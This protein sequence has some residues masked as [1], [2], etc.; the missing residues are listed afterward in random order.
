MNNKNITL[1]TDSYKIGHHNQYPK[2][3]R[4]VYSYFEARKGAKYSDTTFFG[5]QALLKKY[6]AGV[7]VTSEIVDKAETIIDA[8]LGPDTF[9][10]ERW[11][12]IVEK[13]KGKLPVRIKAVPEGM[14]IPI[15]NVMMTVENTDPDCFWLTNHLETILTHVWHAS[16]VATLS[17]HTKKDMMDYLSKTSDNPDAINFMLHDFGF[18]GVS[19]LESAESGGAGHLI[20]FLGT[21]TVPA[22]IFI[23]DYYNTTEVAGYS[24][25]A[26][27]HSV[28]TAVGK[29]REAEVIGHLLEEYPTGIISVVSDSYDIFNCAENIIGGMYKEKILERDGKFVVRPDSGEPVST[30]LNLLEILGN[31]FGFTENSK[32][33][34]VLNPK[35]GLIWGDGIDHDGINAILEAM[36]KNKWAADNAV[37]GCGG[38]LLQKINRDTQ[39]FAFKSSAQLRNGVWHDVYKE[40]KDMSKASKRGRLKLVE[41][42]GSHGKGFTTVREDE[43]GEDVLITVFENGELLN[44]STFEEIRK[45]AKIN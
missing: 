38:G 4:G 26:T 34:K 44:Q 13:H 30:M 19:S 29:E 7:V 41:I 37:F 31:K 32:G 35:I 9:H 39:R 10:R 16:T 2:N 6:L 45:R 21:D 33:F 11:D 24:V 23:M 25:V 28:M 22:L 15:N 36:A 42:D 43:P 12:H 8:H 40:P 20:N 17:R 5:L 27:E 14:T 3:T 18:R 1:L